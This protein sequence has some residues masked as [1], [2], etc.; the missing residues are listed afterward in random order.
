MERDG[1]YFQ[2]RDE[3]DNVC[4]GIDREGNSHQSAFIYWPHCI[5]NTYS[6]YKKNPRI[7]LDP[8]RISLDKR[9]RNIRA[10]Y[11][12]EAEKRDVSILHQIFMTTYFV[13]CAQR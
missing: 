4:V 8:L 12:R 6:R 7:W 5:V 10:A 11:P 1:V 3:S 2:G 9:F 13:G